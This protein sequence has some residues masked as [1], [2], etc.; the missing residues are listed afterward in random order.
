MTRNL[1]CIACPMGCGIT[2]EL[3]GGKIKSIV[4]NTCPRGA[5]YARNECTNPKRIITT[6][7]RCDNGAV[8]PVKTD[9]AIP[10][11][12][13]FESMKIINN[14]IAHLPITAGDVIIK[15]VFGSNVVA[16]RGVSADACYS[17][18]QK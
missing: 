1:T 5:E 13:M 2:I 7:I 10:K 9:T 17:S 14:T 16:T 4:G 6:T 12:K 15:D 18:G 3:D 8:V 11:D